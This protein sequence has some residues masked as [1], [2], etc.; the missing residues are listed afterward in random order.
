MLPIAALLWVLAALVL[1]VLLYSARMM[2][3]NTVE[4]QKALIDNSLSL[5]LSQSL[6]ELRSVAWWDEAVIK[7]RDTKFDAAWLDVEVGVF[8]T[9]SY[10]H[11][12]V[13]IF[14]EG[15]Q[16]VYGFGSDARLSRADQLKFARS[17]RPLIEQIRGG[18]NASP[19]IKDPSLLTEHKEDSE[20]T[21]RSYGRGAAAILSID[22]RPALASVM[23]ITPSID[24]ELNAERPRLLASVIDVSPA[25]LGEI[26]KS[27]LIP[28]LKIGRR[29]AV[30]TGAKATFAL[31]SDT[32]EPFGT[33]N[34]SPPH[35]GAAL[36]EDV[37]PLLLLIAGIV[38]ASIVFL[39]RRLVASAKSLSDRE[40]DAQYLANH[41]ALTGLPNRRMLIRSM[42]DMAAVNGADTH[43]LLACIDLDR[44]KD[45]NDTMGHQAGDALIR[46]VAARFASAV[47]PGDV[48]ARL[49]GDELAVLSLQSGKAAEE[50]MARALRDCFAEPYAIMGQLVET[51][52]SV[53]ITVGT[54]GQKLEDVLRKADIAMYEAKSLGRGQV[55]MFQQHMALRLEQRHALE[56]DLKRAIANNE[57]TLNYQPIV[58][59]STGL[60]TSVEALLRWNSPVHGNV[61]PP[62]FI[63]IAE[64]AG[65]MADIGRF[66]INRAMEDS[67][68]W[69]DIETAINISPAQLRSATILQDL[70]ES[71]SR[72]SVSPERIML[73]ITETVLLANDQRTTDTLNQLKACGFRLALDDFGTGYSSISYIRDFPFDELKIDRSFVQSIDTSPR[74]LAIIEAIVVLADKTGLSIVAEGIEEQREMQIMQQVGCSRLQ[75]YL[76]SKPLPAAHIE[77]LAATLG[78]REPAFGGGQAGEREDFTSPE[79]ALPRKRPSRIG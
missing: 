53:G 39:S 5:R 2:D 57:L 46:A 79:I 29:S 78:Q 42:K 38:A 51:T 64:E 73:E 41:D 17:L 36:I 52:A 9:T 16:P 77:A 35:P 65:M 63:Q 19:R 55:L 20:I 30:T 75:G 70:L 71:A 67:R 12:R 25:L 72:F 15:D 33:L 60:I 45:I 8:V 1:T 11:D 56:V 44:F 58:N 4:R 49:G 21:D 68:R 3:V 76:F 6:S 66:V 13:L 54:V 22:G 32:G 31:K 28:D 34:W 62:V 10:A 43:F 37:L 48:L 47:A 7:S 74:S 69:P 26:G 18:P 50:R 27:V 40:A 23:A 61:A 59:A 14:D 24:M